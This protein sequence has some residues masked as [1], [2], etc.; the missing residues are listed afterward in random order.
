[1]GEQTVRS[2]SNFNDDGDVLVPYLQVVFPV[3]VSHDHNII[4]CSVKHLHSVRRVCWTANSH[5]A[6]WML[7]LIT[8]PDTTNTL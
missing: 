2:R 3:N 8:A 7:L 6:S 5:T 4:L 1:M